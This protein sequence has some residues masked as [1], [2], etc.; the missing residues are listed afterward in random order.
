MGLG[1]E[2]D[3]SVVIKGYQEGILWSFFLIE[4]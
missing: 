3:V 2:R 4:V 1:S